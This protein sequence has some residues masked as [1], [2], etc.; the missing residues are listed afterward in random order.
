MS[1]IKRW[2]A[3]VRNVTPYVPGEQPQEKDIIKLNTNENPYPPSPKVFEAHRNVDVSRFSLYPE[4]SA[5]TLVVSLAEYHKISEK[6]I[7]VGVGSDDV[8]SMSFLT[9][10]N[11]QKPI[12][13]PDI[14]YSFY[15]VW[16]EVYRIP[17]ECPPLKEDFTIDA[18]DYKRENG[19]I[20]IANPNA[21]T[22]IGMPF[23]EIE[24]IVKANRD[25]VVIIDE[26]YVDF[27]GET[28]LPLIKK[29]DNLLVV[30]TYSKSRSMA[31]MR[32]GYAMGNE[33]LIQAMTD[34]KESINSYTM[35]TESIL[36]G[37]AALKDEAY[38]Q[39]S[40]KKVLD[41]RERS[42]TALEKLGFE[43]KDSQTNFLFASHE[44]VPAKEIFEK[45]RENGIYVRYF[46]KERICNYLRITVGTDEEMD[47]FLE[48]VERIVKAG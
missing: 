33:A 40:L 39:E 2:A 48:A 43:V 46:N 28:V 37:A 18:D 15:P 19:G 7:F 9:F 14:T 11:S 5:K 16:A 10:F 27:G 35:N 23:S 42:R 41:T 32:I 4:L 47:R 22:S 21:P 20:V 26:A 8:L 34:V 6:E 45:L 30:R 24:E 36:V 17:F 38:F 25:V 44:N 13:F 12:L 1:E 31:G 3:N 29:Y